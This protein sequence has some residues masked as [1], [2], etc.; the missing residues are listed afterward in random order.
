MLSG[1]PAGA[2]QPKTGG[3][4]TDQ[5]FRS[6]MLN[7]AEDYAKL[8]VM[9]Q[10]RNSNLAIGAALFSIIDSEIALLLGGNMFF[11]IPLHLCAIWFIY[12]AFS[13]RRTARIEFEE[14][15][16]RRQDVLNDLWNTLK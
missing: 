9:A 7:C 11:N 13:H 12:M 8:A 6:K 2:E 1:L 16:E 15:M 14:R 10:R 4:M 3:I 5:E